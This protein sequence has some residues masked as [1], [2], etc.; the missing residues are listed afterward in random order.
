MELKLKDNNIGGIYVNIQLDRNLVGSNLSKI[1]EGKEQ[2][3]LDGQKVL[4]K[5]FRKKYNDRD[6]VF[7][8]GAELSFV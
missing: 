4:I 7:L 1:L 2:L 6:Y 8:E 5:S 3:E